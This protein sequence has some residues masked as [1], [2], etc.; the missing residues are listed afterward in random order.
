MN[1][2]EAA[3]FPKAVCVHDLF[4]EAQ[5]QV[6]K[7]LLKDCGRQVP[8]ADRHHRLSVYIVQ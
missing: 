1:L 4:K 2:T 6:M 5:E 7:M 8:D 3:E